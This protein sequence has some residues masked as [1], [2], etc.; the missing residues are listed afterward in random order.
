MCSSRVAKIVS[1][2]GVASYQTRLHPGKHRMREC[3]SLGD[4]LQQIHHISSL[5]FGSCWNFSFHGNYSAEVPATDSSIRKCQEPCMDFSW[6]WSARPSCCLTVRPDVLGDQTGINIHTY[7]TFF[8]SF[9]TRPL[10]LCV[11]L[12][13]QCHKKSFPSKEILWLVEVIR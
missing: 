8:Y 6:D 13:K 5:C 4:F 2:K 12:S 3:C 10:Y 1:G 7:V 9:G 11:K